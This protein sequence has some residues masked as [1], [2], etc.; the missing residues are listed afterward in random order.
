MIELKPSSAEAHLSFGQV[1]SGP[2][3]TPDPMAGAY[4]M[5]IEL[6]PD[7]AMTHYNLGNV[8]RD[9]GDLPG[10]IAA[11]RQAIELK[12]DYAEAH[13]NLGLVLGRT[14]NFDDALV[15]LRRGH[16][17]GSKRPDWRYPSAQWV[18]QA[19]RMLALSK[20]FPAVL[21]GGDK[22]NDNPERLAFAQMAYDH[23]HFAAAARLWA[24]ALASDPKLG[25]D[26]QYP[27]PL[28]RRLRRG[29]G[30]RGARQG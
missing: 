21:R 5:A 14:G 27:A 28:Q 11:F 3:E 20:R 15:K 18:A 17:L 10:A 2:G 8:L 13:C 25:D 23:K 19:E 16:E 4:P 9:S 24:E 22:P 30:R 1:V 7:Y 26:R 6:K 29:P 12:P